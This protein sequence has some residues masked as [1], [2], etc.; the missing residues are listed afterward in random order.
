M[1][2]QN[3]SF[4]YQWAHGHAKPNIFRHDAFAKEKKKDQYLK[5]LGSGFIQFLKWYN[6]TVFI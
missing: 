5:S 1:I 3:I 6:N 2:C 4:E